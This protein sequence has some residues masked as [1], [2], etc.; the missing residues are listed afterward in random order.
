MEAEL[1]R[2][3]RLRVVVAAPAFMLGGQARAAA[4]IVNGFR[5]DAEIEVILQPI[6]PRLGGGWSR[7]TS[8]PFFRSIVRPLLYVRALSREAAKADAV[9]VFCA[10]HTA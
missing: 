1:E 10:A 9:H 6:D 7:L 2:R 8:W 5:N 3:P 4:D